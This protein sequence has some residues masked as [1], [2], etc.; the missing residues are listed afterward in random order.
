MYHGEYGIEK[1]PDGKRWTV[2]EAIDDDVIE[3]MFPRMNRIS[4]D[5]GAY[6]GLEGDITAPRGSTKLLDDSATTF[7]DPRINETTEKI[8]MMHLQV[9]DTEEDEVTLDVEDGR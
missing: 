5:G 3:N 8:P 9:K 4:P 7:Y 6:P 2:N 1:T